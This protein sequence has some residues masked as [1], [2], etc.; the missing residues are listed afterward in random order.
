MFN[1][2]SSK[3]TKNASPD[4]PST[5]KAEETPPV[6]DDI[7]D[8]DDD[9]NDKKSPI[10]VPTIS[11]LVATAAT[12]ISLPP[13]PKN[14]AVAPPPTATSPATASSAAPASVPP[15]PATPVK[16]S[17][18][19][20]KLQKA[21]D[22]WIFNYHDPT[23]PID[24]AL[25][26]APIATALG[27][28]STTEQETKCKAFYD[29]LCANWTDLSI[30]NA[31]T[32]SYV[33]AVHIPGTRM[34]KIC[35][36]LGS[37]VSF[38]GLGGSTINNYALAMSGDHQPGIKFPSVMTFP[39]N[40]ISDQITIQNPGI[41]DLFD[42][43]QKLGTQKQQMSKLTFFPSKLA[44]RPRQVLPIAPIPIYMVHDCIDNNM[45][46]LL[47][48][49]RLQAVQQ[50][51]L[52]FFRTNCPS[53]YK[54]AI[55]YCVNA[56]VTTTKK[57]TSVGF[58]LAWYTGQ[59]VDQDAERWKKQRLEQQFPTIFG[60]TPP[61][62]ATSVPTN[63]LPTT[64]PQ[65][66]EQAK[67]LKSL[68]IKQLQQPQTTKSDEYN[69]KFLGMSESEYDKLLQLSYIKDGDIDK[70]PRFWQ[71]MAEKNRSKEG[72]KSD[73]RNAL[74][75]TKV[76]FKDAKIKITP[77]LITMIV[78]RAFEGDVSSS[79]QAATKGLTPFA[80]PPMSNAELDD[81]NALDS[82]INAATS[83]STSDIKKTKLLLVEVDNYSELM[84]YLKE[85]ANLIAVL[86][87]ERCPLWCT[88]DDL[89]DSLMDYTEEERASLQRASCNAILWIIMRQSRSFAAGDM[90]EPDDVLPEYGEMMMAI[91]VRRK[92]EF[93]GL[94][95]SMKRKPEEMLQAEQAKKHRGNNGGN[96]GG[97]NNNN[98]NNKKAPPE[99]TDKGVQHPK[100][101]QAFE[102]IKT[103]NRV[104][105]QIFRLCEA[106]DT[107]HHLLFPNR[108]G[109]CAKAQI[110]GACPKDCK[111][112]HIKISD[113]EAEAVIRK[114]K[115]ALD[116][117]GQFKLQVQ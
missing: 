96:G 102:T 110:F 114:L 34:L 49:D 35:Y 97:H 29:F 107:K 60:P 72:K 43:N 65:D 5:N 99:F 78:T 28:L 26:Q 44:T 1:L 104:P 51:D 18:A 58:P 69:D 31:D 3:T 81:I 48:L 13:K 103:Q 93:L 73:V 109:M 38:G 33:F 59:H 111:H 11:T 77:S 39:L 36:G 88:L 89:I 80:L 75:T 86:F 52:E 85:Y 17:A 24:P 41:Y 67:L 54:H 22:N 100:L 42:L 94:P 116:N 7:V 105:P 55:R 32:T 20:I 46:V 84:R 14:V 8:S 115:K 63:A 74:R 23:S 76:K 66:D 62:S 87:T 45:D 79:K 112:T 21:L 53:V 37:G 4:T 57:T 113:N 83:V 61:P 117:P 64:T 47:L 6:R 90:V 70:L 106:C 2:R 30:L 98:N 101:A 9:D 82:D 15:V 12:G 71:N 16:L 40:D 95:P 10:L 108:P 68:L 92:I 25:L 27:T 19:E 56:L 91:T 50:H